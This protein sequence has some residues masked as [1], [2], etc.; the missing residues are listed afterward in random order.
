MA[1]RVTD[2]AGPKDPSGKP[3]MTALAQRKW[4][5]RQKMSEV[6]TSVKWRFG[7]AG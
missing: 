2:N 6:V 1:P 3:E 4:V 7:P 5:A